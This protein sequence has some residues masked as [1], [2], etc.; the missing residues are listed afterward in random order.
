M[1]RQH[2]RS[3]RPLARAF[4]EPV[5]TTARWVKPKE[6]PT[7]TRRRPR[8]VSDDLVMRRRVQE[9]ADHPRHRTFGYRRLGA[10]LRRE[11]VSINPKTVRRIMRDLGLSWPKFA[12]KPQRPKRVE[13]IRRARPNQGWQVDMTSFALSDFTPLFLVTVIACCTR[14]VVGWTLE[15]R[16][17]PASG[18]RRCGWRWRHVG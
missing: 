7:P 11:G 12:Y 2:K 3:V 8:P 10:L 4:D 14:E 5:S 13:T 1:H 15:R 16:C 9:L 6:A 18:R 17:R